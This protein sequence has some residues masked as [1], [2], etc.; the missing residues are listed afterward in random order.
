MGLQE[1]F[2]NETV[3][4][5]DVRDAVQ[6]PNT[7][8]LGETV[9]K[10]RE[11]NIGCAFVIDDDQKPI[12]MLTESM[13]T[14]LLSHGPLPLNDPIEKHVANRWQWVKKTDPIADVLE[15]M[16]LK[17][18]RML[19]VVDENDQVVGVTGQRG[20]MEYV[21][22]HF[23]GQVMVQRVGQSPYLSDREGA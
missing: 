12:G 10:M 18:I 14:E 19:G 2:R 13:L 15:A 17:N 22:E 21:A 5:L 3:E 6:V 16:E 7:V 1:N 4:Q 11:L 23:P 20:L 8:T 9:A